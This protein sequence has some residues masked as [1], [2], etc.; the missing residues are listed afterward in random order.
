MLAFAHSSARYCELPLSWTQSC[1][2]SVS[3]CRRR[4][5]LSGPSPK[6]RSCQ[7]GCSRA[8][9]DQAVTAWSICFSAT[10]RPAI[11][12][13]R[14][15]RVERGRKPPGRALGTTS[16][17]GAAPARVSANQSLVRSL[18]TA[19]ASSRGVYLRSGSPLVPRSSDTRCSWWTVMT[20]A[21][22]SSTASAIR[23]G[24]VVTR[25]SVSVAWRAS[26]SSRSESRLKAASQ[27]R[28]TIRLG[29]A[30]SSTRTLSSTPVVRNGRGVPDVRST[31]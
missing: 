27:D 18:R 5:P 3:I 28:S 9:V 4:A 21:G 13:V 23:A 15:C 11:T 30:A 8:T 29:C 14:V 31:R 22:A 26:S 25:T 19:S 10:R 12:T 7:S 20:C 1:S 17:R 24:V 16:R 2:P 6:M